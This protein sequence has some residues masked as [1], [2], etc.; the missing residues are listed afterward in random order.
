MADKPIFVGT[1]NNGPLEIENGDGTT[2]Q[3]L[4]TPGSNGCKV[5][6]INVVSTD[7]A[8]VELQLWVTISAVDYLLGTVDITTLAGTDGA[9]AAVNLLASDKIAM[10][11]TNGQIALD[12][13]EVLKIAPKAAVTAATKVTVFAQAAD[14]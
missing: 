3:T 6:N 13:G 14:Y 1:I 12:N 4:I 5:L 7:T 8:T 11:D 2:L 9:E 10:T